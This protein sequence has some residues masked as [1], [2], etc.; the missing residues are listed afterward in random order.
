MSYTWLGQSTSLVQL[1]GVTILTDPVFAAQPLSSVFAP[2]RLRPPAISTDALLALDL[3]D[4]ICISHN[5]YDH[6]DIEFVRAVVANEASLP[7][8]ERVKWIV[9][10][11]VKTFLVTQGVAEAQVIDMDWWQE[12]VITVRHGKKLEVA[13]TPAQHWSGRTPL[14]TNRSLWCGFVLR[15][16]DAQRNGGQSFFHAGDTG[17]SSGKSYLPAQI[18]CSG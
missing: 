13:C 4:V 5:H 3:L 18:T 6:L 8:E 7:P 11:G 1:S 15:E 14:D 9:P 17:Y 2:T 12:E 10:L 16:P